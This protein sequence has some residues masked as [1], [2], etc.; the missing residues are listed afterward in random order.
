MKNIDM[1]ALKKAVEANNAFL[2][3]LRN[4]PRLLDLGKKMQL[5][6]KNLDAAGIKAGKDDYWHDM[7]VIAAY[8][9]AA[10]YAEVQAGKAAWKQAPA[11]DNEDT[12]MAA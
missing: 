9:V 2:E 10:Q 1:E 8:C 4:D 7:A 12:K 6:A 11:N 3:K 5:C